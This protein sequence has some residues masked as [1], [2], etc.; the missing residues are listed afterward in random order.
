MRSWPPEKTPLSPSASSFFN[1]RSRYFTSGTLYINPLATPS[2]YWRYSTSVWL[3]DGLSVVGSV[4]WHGYT[5]SL[6]R[7]SGPNRFLS[8]E[9][10]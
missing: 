6:Y 5:D 7:R 1:G 9:L 2:P 4:E 8:T 10:L 3:F